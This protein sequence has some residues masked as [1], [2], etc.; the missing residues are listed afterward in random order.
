MTTAQTTG[1]CAG[2]DPAIVSV[3]V[4]NVSSDGQVKTYHLGGRVVNLGARAQASNDLYFVDVYENG[5]KVDS[6]GIPPLHPGQAYTFGYDYKRNVAA[7]NGSTRFRFVLDWRQP[8]PPG[9]QDCNLANG[10]FSLRV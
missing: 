6:R 5:I 7:A 4:K 2:A 1:G 10:T 3:A 9:S 8:V